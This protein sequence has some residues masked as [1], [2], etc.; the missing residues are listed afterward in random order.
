MGV[1]YGEIVFSGD[2]KEKGG[3]TRDFAN[4][5]KNAQNF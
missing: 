4:L 2:P 1:F 5:I 3:L